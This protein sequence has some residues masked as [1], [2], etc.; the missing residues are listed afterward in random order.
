[1][2]FR[3]ISGQDVIKILVK[4]FGFEI[5]RQSGSHVILRKYVDGKKITTVVPLHDD[6]K[7]GTLLGILS[8]ARI[9]KDEFLDKT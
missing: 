2:K 6:I 5:A 1:L 7:P 8:L 4:E 9:S 3:N